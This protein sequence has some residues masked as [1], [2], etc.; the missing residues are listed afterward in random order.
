MATAATARPAGAAARAAPRRPLLASRPRRPHPTSPARPCPPRRASASPA[1]GGAAPD[2]PPAAAEGGPLAAARRFFGLDKKIGRAELGKLGAGGV[3]AYSAVSNVNYGTAIGI[4]W[5]AFVKQKGLSP[6][7]DQ[8]PTFLAFYAGM[9]AVQNFLRPARFAL[10]LALAPG[11]NRLIDRVGEATGFGRRGA[12]GILLA[13]MAV[14]MTTTLGL[15]LW[16]FGGF[17]PPPK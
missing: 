6:L 4:S 12:F 10:A 8:W 16:A 15:A 7:G 13:A 14:T 3:L 5:I 17:P 11:A 2:P 1:D 9:W